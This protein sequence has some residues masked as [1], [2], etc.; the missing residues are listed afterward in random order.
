MLGRSALLAATNSAAEGSLFLNNTAGASGTINAHA[1]STTTLVNSNTFTIELWMHTISTVDMILLSDPSGN[2]KQIFRMNFPSVGKIGMYAY[3]SGGQ[4]ISSSGTYALTGWKHLAFVCNNGSNTV[5]VNGVAAVQY[6][7]SPTD[8]GRRMGYLGALFSG[9]QYHHFRGHISRYRITNAVRYT[10]NFT[11]TPRTLP[12][13]TDTEDPLWSSVSGA[14]DLDGST[15]NK[16]NNR[17]DDFVLYGSA[18]FTPS[19]A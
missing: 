16:K 14:F 10:A 5:Y 1:I 19:P 2:N 3:P 13:P 18:A 7:A 17:T 11:P 9:N 12:L 8:D 6:S 15:L 4:L